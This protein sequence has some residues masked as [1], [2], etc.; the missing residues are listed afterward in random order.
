MHRLFSISLVCLLVVGL[1]HKRTN[2]QDDQYATLTPLQYDGQSVSQVELATPLTSIPL[3]RREATGILAY[4]P[5]VATISDPDN[6]ISFSGSGDSRLILGYRPG[7]YVNGTVSTIFLGQHMGY[8][9]CGFFKNEVANSVGNWLNSRPNWLLYGIMRLE[10]NANQ[11]NQ[12]SHVVIGNN[13]IQS[14]NGWLSGVVRTRDGNGIPGRLVF[15]VDGI[16]PI[17]SP[18]GLVI[19]VYDDA[20]PVITGSANT[21]IGAQGPIDNDAVGGNYSGTY[22]FLVTREENAPAPI[23]K[24]F[25]RNNWFPDGQ[26]GGG[27]NGDF[28]GGAGGGF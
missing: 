25:L 8:D 1:H 19:D 22:A 7:T 11:V 26:N 17:F 9:T 14:D 23:E 18:G 20:P 24:W 3:F 12:H 28:S 6:L 10:G 4:A 21:C 13:W 5:S 15:G 16:P 2:A 27:A